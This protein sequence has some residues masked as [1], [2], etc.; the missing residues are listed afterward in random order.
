MD[1]VMLLCGI[2]GFALKQPVVMAKVFG[3]LERLEVHQ[4]PNELKPVGGFGAGVAVVKS[5]GSV[6]CE[7]VGK[8]ADSPAKRLS[9]MVKIGEAK[10]LVGHVRMP[11]PQFMDTA[12]FRETAQPYV[13]KCRSGLSV[14]SV[15]NG[16]VENYLQ[17]KE[18]LG[19][20]HVFES[21]RVGFVDSEVVPHFFEQLLGENATVGEALNAFFAGVEGSNTIGLLH[22]AGERVFLHV[23]H[24]GKTR[25]LTVWMN[26]EGGVIFCGRKEPLVEAFDDVLK[27][28]KFREKF[29]IGWQEDAN[30]KV[31]FPLN[32][33]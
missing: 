24:K 9:C 4:F 26:D 21:D 33:C 1:W 19:E 8:V 29:S 25:G 16:Y 2:F 5:D 32:V 7:K 17:I 30:V 28:G 18:R 10:V 14:V 20:A 15:H 12:R 27:Q 6:F 23:V 13:A 22:V 11:S 3:V 31:S